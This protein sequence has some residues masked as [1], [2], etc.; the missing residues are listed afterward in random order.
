MHSL[1]QKIISSKNP[2]KSKTGSLRFTVELDTKSKNSYLHFSLKK[3]ILDH[4]KKEKIIKK[5]EKKSPNPFGDEDSDE[6]VARIAAKFEQKY[7]TCYDADGYIDKG[8]GYD[9]NDPF[10]DN[11]EAYDELIPHNITTEHG[12]FYINSGELK[13]K[14]I[15]ENQTESEFEKANLLQKL[16]RKRNKIEDSHQESDSSRKKQTKAPKQIKVPKEQKKA[17]LSD[18]K[19]NC[20]NSSM[21]TSIESFNQSIESKPKKTPN[22]SD[23]KKES[24]KNSSSGK[25]SES[26]HQNESQKVK[27]SK[28]PVASDNVSNVKIQPNASSMNAS[29]ADVVSMAQNYYSS[30]IQ[31][32]ITD[33]LL[34]N[35]PSIGSIN[36]TSTHLYSNLQPN[37]TNL[38]AQ[39]QNLALLRTNLLSLKIPYDLITALP[40]NKPA[41]IEGTISPE[42]TRYLVELY[43]KSASSSKNRLKLYDCLAK[44]IG[45]GLTGETLLQYIQHTHL[46]L[47]VIKS[48]SSSTKSSSSLNS[49]STAYQSKKMLSNQSQAQQAI[50]LSMNP[51]SAQSSFS[52]GLAGK[53]VHNN[54][55]IETMVSNSTKSNSSSKSTSLNSAKTSNSKNSSIS[56]KTK[57]ESYGNLAMLKSLSFLA[58]ST[59][60]NQSSTKSSSM[61][62]TSSNSMP[63]PLAPSPQSL[64]V[65]SNSSAI[66]T[67]RNNS[68]NSLLA[69]FNQGKTSPGTPI[70]SS[71]SQ[72]S[73]ST[74]TPTTS[75]VSSTVSRAEILSSFFQ[76]PNMFTNANLINHFLNSSSQ[77]STPT[78]STNSTTNARS[79]GKSNSNLNQSSILLSNNAGTLK[80]HSLNVS[81]QSSK[82]ASF[83][84]PSQNSNSLLLA[85]SSTVVGS[86]QSPTSIIKSSN[87]STVASNSTSQQSSSST[88]SSVVVNYMK[89]NQQG[90]SIGLPNQTANR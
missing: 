38:S 42:W 52:E 68:N 33:S 32:M 14:N 51:S 69:A 7:G 2:S 79:S 75:S 77:S 67:N 16:K 22:N 73:F 20:I 58:S 36:S 13:F 62:T 34:G 47:N 10:V 86:P 35:I 49:T 60:N 25:K 17:Q 9:E 5:D 41:T 71:K 43:K 83:A 6:E 48:S 45:L 87:R 74:S 63:P 4:Q 53:L 11:S 81:S 24:R 89:T 90:I 31:Q 76:I 23:N 80:S 55:Q 28:Y 54:Q 59:S 30:K 65:G 78:L 21:N 57:L 18:N 61:I 19:D 12:G 84:S 88:K 82:S 50:N 66:Q 29:T 27:K 26:N 44:F 39:N 64:V 85:Q 40:Y 72:A 56:Q 8:E 3:M 37:I 70:S 15:E 1:G 46:D